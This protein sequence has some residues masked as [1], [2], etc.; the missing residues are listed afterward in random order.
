MCM[1]EGVCES[2]CAWERECVRV[3]VHGRGRVSVCAWER[4]CVSVC[5]GEGV[6][7][8]VRVCMGEGE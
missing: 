7:E 1:G 3:C 2:V 6:C 4:E 8:C 5:M